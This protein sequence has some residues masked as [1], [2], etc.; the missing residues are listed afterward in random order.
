[1]FPLISA[2]AQLT[3]PPDPGKG[4]IVDGVPTIKGLEAVFENTISVVLGLA[5]IVFFIMLVVGGFKYITAGGEPKQVE[6]ARKTLT[7][8]VLG[9]IGIAAAFL[10]L[11]LIHS[12]TG[13]NI[14]EFK[15]F[16]PLP[17]P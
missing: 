8:A 5:G 17:A 2:L 11:R 10:I 4:E 6:S 13:A 15:I 9:I 3:R 1:M 12:F 14:T 7:Y 16:Q